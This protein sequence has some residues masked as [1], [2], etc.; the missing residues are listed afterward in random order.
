MESYGNILILRS[1]NVLVPTQIPGMI[2][3]K[4]VAAG[5]G[6]S[7]FLTSKGEVFVLGWNGNGELGLGDIRQVDYPTKIPELSG[8]S[9]VS[10]QASAS[11][12]MGERSDFATPHFFHYPPPSR[13]N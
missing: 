13:T 1:N 12:G 10:T 2:D 3:V 6:S 4:A 5:T 11:F 7:F 9:L 8:V